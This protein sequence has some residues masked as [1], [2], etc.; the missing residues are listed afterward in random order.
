MIWIKPR[1]AVRWHRFLC[2]Y[3]CSIESTFLKTLRQLVAGDEFIQLA[4]R[5]GLLSLLI[6]WS[7]VL[8]RP[9]VP[10][11]AWSVV[12]AVALYPVFNWLT[13][14]L[15]GHAGIAALVLTLIALAVVIGPA[16][17]LG[18]GSSPDN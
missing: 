13:G 1:V 6:Y 15:G 12:L 3:G 8:V 10:I 7:F 5:L 18:I 14:M 17:W 9:F 2:A 16:T 4:I 11:L